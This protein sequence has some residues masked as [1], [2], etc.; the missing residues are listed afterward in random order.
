[1]RCQQ[2]HRTPQGTV[3]LGRGVRET[4]RN[5]DVPHR[6]HPGLRRARSGAAG[7]HVPIRPQRKEY[8]GKTADKREVRSIASQGEPSYG[9]AQSLPSL[10]LANGLSQAAQPGALQPKLKRQ[11]R[12][13]DHSPVS[14]AARGSVAGRSWV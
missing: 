14:S 2:G 9:F 8:S 3:V 7:K 13:A 6:Y 10:W 4:H 5:W 12:E 11:R 1:M